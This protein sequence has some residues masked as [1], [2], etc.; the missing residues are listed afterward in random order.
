[1]LDFVPA[2]EVLLFRQKRLV[3]GG[4]TPYNILL[5]SKTS[6]MAWA[7]GKVRLVLPTKLFYMINNNS[8]GRTAADDKAKERAKIPGGKNPCA[9]HMGHT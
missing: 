5:Q 8:S 2:D 4:E 3:A 7:L 6:W 1:M 9:I